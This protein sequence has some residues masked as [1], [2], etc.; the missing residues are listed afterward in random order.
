MLFDV[1]LALSPLLLILVAI[2][3]CN[4]APDIA[5]GIAWV[6]CIAV[7]CLYFQTDFSVALMTSLSGLVASLPIALVLAAAMFQVTV[8]RETGAMSRLAVLCKTL[9][10]HDRPTQILLLNCAFAYIL[11]A[12]GAVPMTVLPAVMLPLGYTV[13]Q[14]VGLPIMGYSGGC[15]FSLLG[16]PGQ[17][18]ATFCGISTLEAWHVLAR[19]MPLTNFAVAAACLWFAGGPPMFKKGFIPAVLIGFGSW[20]GVKAGAA[21]HVMP[22]TGILSG[23]IMT[24]LLAIFLRLRGSLVIDRSMLDVEDLEMERRLSLI[25]AISPWLMLTI[26]AIAINTPLLPLHRIFFTDT[27]MTVEI[28]PGH[29][30]HLRILSQPY[31]WL[32]VATLASTPFLKSRPGL[33][34]QCLRNW[35]RRATRPVLAAAIYFAIAY[36]FNHSG[37]NAAWELIG[38]HNNMITVL[39]AAAAQTFGVL[40]CA[41]ASFIGVAAGLVCGSQVA[42]TAMLT[43]LHLKTSALLNIDGVMVASGGAIGAGV[44]GILSPAKLM[45][46]ASSI[47]KP[48]EAGGIFRSLMGLCAFITCSIALVALAYTL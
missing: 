28:I 12:L 45:S 9:A 44:A 22:V 8:M 48:G 15:S 14:S 36:V 7:S 46:S 39:A 4:T 6:F 3:C 47:D 20:A 5:G 27:P 37:K 11:M 42:G 29:P 24:A 23:V 10:A 16:I 17:V 38:P 35:L 13:A 1:L 31:L 34:R 19:Y 21:L 2:A 33:I 43:V 32:F 25:A 26:I 41:A 30:E 18:L 40:Y